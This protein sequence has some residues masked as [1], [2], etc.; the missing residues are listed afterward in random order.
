[1]AHSPPD[2]HTQADTYLSNLSELAGHS[3]ASTQEA[4]EAILRLIVDRLGLRS[5]FLTRID[6]E[7]CQHEV[8]MAQNLAGGSDIQVGVVMK[9]SQTF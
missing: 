5:S 9:L 2:Q 6:Q 7:E 8:I 1:M 4:V 3:F